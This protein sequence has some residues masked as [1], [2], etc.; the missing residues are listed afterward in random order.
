MEIASARTSHRVHALGLGPSSSKGQ[1]AMK[2]NMRRLIISTCSISTLIVAGGC[3]SSGPDLSTTEFGP[4]GGSEDVGQQRQEL[5]HSFTSIGAGYETSIGL[6]S[7]GTVWTWGVGTYGKLGNG[8]TS[9]QEN[10]PVQVLAGA[11]GTGFLTGVTAIFGGYQRHFAVKGS[12]L[13]GWGSNSSGALGDGSGTMQSTPVKISLSSPTRVDSGDV[14]T[15]AT[16]GS[17]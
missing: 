7:D 6:K 1:R 15:L 3:T 13:W 9:G 12:E 17:L 14:H 8:T 11:S 4:G 10:C 16:S 2:Y 5:T